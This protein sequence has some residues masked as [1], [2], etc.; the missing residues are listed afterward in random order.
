MSIQPPEPPESPLA[1]LFVALDL[2]SAIRSQIAAWGADELR[3]PALRAV[4]DSNLH[5]TL[6]FLGET[7]FE[8]IPRVA[9]TAL[10]AVGEAPLLELGPDPVALPRGRRAGVYGIDVR[11]PEAEALQAGIVS[12]LADAGLHQPEERPYWPHL[13]IARVRKVR[14]ARGKRMKVEAPPGRLP[15][16]LLQP[17]RAVRMALYL[18]SFGPDGVR[19]TP[20]AQVELHSGEAAV[21]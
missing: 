7:P 9:G 3:D 18:S 12:A 4:A 8:L 15:E 17:F 2:P 10:G 6:V 14:G 1:R 11:S 13:T 20:L 21:R 19:Y 16:A 5:I